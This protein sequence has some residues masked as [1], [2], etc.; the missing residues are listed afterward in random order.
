MEKE[1]LSKD[2]A[3]KMWGY[4]KES[5]TGVEKQQPES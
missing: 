4:G 3:L 1:K 5:E 2:K